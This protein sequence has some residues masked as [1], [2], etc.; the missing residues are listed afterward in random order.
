MGPSGRNEGRAPAEPADRAHVSPA[1]RRRRRARQARARETV[2]AIEQ[3]AAQLFGELGYAATT[4]NRIAR[5]AGV[6][7]GS[8]YQYF[9]DKDSIVLSL[10]EE[11]RRD[12]H[13]LVAEGLDTLRQPDIP[14]RTGLTS[15]IERLAR[16]RAGDPA[17]QRFLG[18]VDHLPGVADGPDADDD[19]VRIV[20]QILRERPEVRIADPRLG[21]WI[22][23]R[24]VESISRWLVHEAPPD[25]DEK[26]FIA[27]VVSMIGGYL[28]RMN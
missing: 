28:E 15:L 21:A 13:V 7:I 2:A 4:T 27:E 6:S 20:E 8:L 5:R 12:I 9:S 23:S 19:F 26:R 1:P 3:A 18:Q 11:H 17:L 24:T 25:L 22:V 14:L 10:V 16:Y